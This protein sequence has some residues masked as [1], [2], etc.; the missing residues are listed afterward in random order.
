MDQISE[1]IKKENIGTE[2]NIGVKSLH[3]LYPSRVNEKIIAD[4]KLKTWD[5]K[6]KKA[7]AEQS[8]RINEFD[9]ANASS[10]DRFE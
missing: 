2:Y 5:E 7:V 3:D 8:R 6:Q 4:L 10:K 9:T 1:A